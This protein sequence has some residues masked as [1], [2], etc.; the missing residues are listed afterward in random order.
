MSD[1]AGISDLVILRC[2]FRLAVWE[3]Q[4]QPN[5]LNWYS[6]FVNGLQFECVAKLWKIYSSQAR[7]G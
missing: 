6:E 7:V 1:V 4:Q 5:E 3:F 2:L